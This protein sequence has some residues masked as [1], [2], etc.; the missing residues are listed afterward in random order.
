M[1]FYFYS[2][3]LCG[4]MAELEPITKKV[5]L[6]GASD[7]GKSVCICFT[8]FRFIFSI[9]YCI[10]VYFRVLFFDLSKESSLNAEKI[11]L[12]VCYFLFS[13]FFFN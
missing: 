12:E 7:A 9:I 11:Q 3:R 4:E 2:F 1:D 5:V 13:I 8:L 6:L 10:L